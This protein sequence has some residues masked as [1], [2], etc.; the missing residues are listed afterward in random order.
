MRTLLLTLLTTLLIGSGAYGYA[1]LTGSAGRDDVH[2]TTRQAAERPGAKRAGWLRLRIRANGLYPGASKRPVVHVHN[3][4]RRRL[5][6][7]SINPRIADQ[8]SNPCARYFTIER[9]RFKKWLPPRAT[10]GV[11]L[12]VEMKPG[13]TDACQGSRVKIRMRA[14]AT[15]R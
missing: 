3:R 14:R 1:Q 13:A 10:R 8:K 9:R 15:K 11:R 7:R 5:K 4:I 2:P 6:L 12:R